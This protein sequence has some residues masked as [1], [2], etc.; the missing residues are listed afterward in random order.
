MNE[1]ARR[2]ARGRVR[3]FTFGKPF[4][5][6]IRVTRSRTNAI[7]QLCRWSAIA[8][9][10]V[11]GRGALTPA[12]AQEV[13]GLT[14]LTAAE[15]VLTRVIQHAEPSVVSIA[16]YKVEPTS[17]TFQRP[18][19]FDPRQQQLLES[20]RP[21]SPDFVPNDFGAGIVIAPSWN[22]DERF[23]LTNYHVVRG[24]PTVRSAEEPGAS[25]KGDSFRLYVRFS[26]RRGYAAQILAADPRSDLAILKIDGAALGRKMTELRPIPLAEAAEVRK[27]QFVISLGNPY[28]IGRDGSASASWGLVSNISRRPAPAGSQLDDETYRRET[29]HHFGTLIHVDTRLNLGTSGGPL[30]NLKGELIGITT[31]L[32]ALDGYEKSAGYAIPIDPHTRRILDD[33]TRGYEVEYGLLGILPADRTADEIHDEYAGLRLPGAAAAETVF[34]NSP[35]ALG[36]LQ[37]KDLIVSINGEPVYGKSDL[38]RIVG[39]LGPDAVALVRVW[40]GRP[41]REIG[42]LR[43]RLG[44]WPVA[45]DE[46]IIAT[47]FRF[48]EWRGLTVDYC[49][50]RKRH[51]ADP[52]RYYKA[53]LLSRVTFSA[54]AA[55]LD[56][57]P[58]DLV[59]HVNSTEVSSPADFHKA[60]EGLDGDVTLRLVDGRRVVIHK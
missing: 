38:M 7:G 27:G 44:K 4:D 50:G 3:G 33:L 40:R 6:Q 11:A 15:S 25:E 39:L 53:V 31:S 1:R 28:A 37:S 54:G 5:G 43:V 48:P 10:I 52:P 42:L 16:R 2:F 30:L 24:G 47:A 55:S 13:D 56:L 32:A 14:I 9:V 12:P 8:L 45:D 58:G 19:F 18:N 26:D 57:K 60:I 21:E 22:R 29:I 46:G 35:A 59:S 23:I 49:T 20:R 51:L 36:G 41:A 17:R 34:P